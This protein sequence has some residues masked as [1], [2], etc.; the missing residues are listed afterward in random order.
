MK[1]SSFTGKSVRDIC[2]LKYVSRYNIN[3]NYTNHKPFSM[4]KS[5][6]MSH[7]LLALLFGCNSI[8]I[9]ALIIFTNNTHKLKHILNFKRFHAKGS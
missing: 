3:T 6:H 5:F 4:A 1:T 8:F 2:S 9:Y 7:S